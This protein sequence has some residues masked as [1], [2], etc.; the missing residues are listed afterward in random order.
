[1]TTRLAD[2]RTADY[3][4]AT[5]DRTHRWSD[6]TVVGRKLRQCVVCYRLAA[7]QALRTPDL[8]P[9]ECYPD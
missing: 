4:P 1:M 3:C 2:K 8:T 5:Q 9:P 7:R 6:R